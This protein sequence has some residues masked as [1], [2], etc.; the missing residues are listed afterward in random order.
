MSD[1]P[2]HLANLRPHFDAQ[3]CAHLGEYADSWRN[4]PALDEV[5]TILSSALAGGKRMRAI[6]GAIGYA[7]ASEFGAYKLALTSPQAA[8]LGTAL[9]FYQASALVHDDVIDHALTRRGQVATHV[10]FSKLHGDNGWRGNDSDF[11]GAAAILAGDALLAWGGDLVTQASEVTGNYGAVN[12]FNH[13]CAEVALGQYLDVR[14]ENLP[15]NGS[16]GEQMVAQSL[17]VIKHKS[18]R[19]SVACPLIIGALLAGASPD[20]PAV[21]ALETYG[22]NVGAAFQLRDDEL[23][24][25]G[26]SKVTG[27]PVGGDIREGK[28][29]VLVGLTWQLTGANGRALLSDVVGNTNASEMQIAAVADLMKDC[30]AYQKHEQLINDYLTRGLACLSH[31]ALGASIIA[32]LQ[33]LA[34][35][36]TIR[37][38]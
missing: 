30:G 36:L 24:V 18:A 16:D 11:G 27:K 8:A 9:E 2:A 34:Q 31:D 35:V 38:A 6:L 13:M 15:L 32:D 33:V 28:R 37:Q 19:Y 29:T 25:F 14:N 21:K 12:A 3:V 23:G 17:A 20:S 4:T 5:F 22:E 1:L 10:A 26:S 7:Y